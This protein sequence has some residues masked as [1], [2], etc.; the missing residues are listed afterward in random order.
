MQIYE[1]MQSSPFPEEWLEEKIEMFHIQDINQDFSENEY[2]K[3]LLE[4]N[5]KEIEL[6]TH[7][8]Q[9]IWL[10]LKEE[11][12][13]K[14]YEL[15]IMEDIETIENLKKQL[16]NWDSAY[17]AIQNIAFPKWPIASSAL[18]SPYFCTRA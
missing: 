5:K 8:L 12:D 9:K 17:Q 15:T 16:H 7:K 3:I 1:F 13:S 18:P 6:A 14:K 2:G 10:D 4:E 11:G